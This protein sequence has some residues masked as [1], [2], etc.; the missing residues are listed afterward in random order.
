MY[1]FRLKAYLG[2]NRLY[3]LDHLRVAAYEHI[4][5]LLPLEIVRREKIMENP[6]PSLPI[7]PSKVRDCGLKPEV[8][9]FLCHP[10]QFLPEKVNIGVLEAEEQRDGN[11]GA[12]IQ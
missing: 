9:M 12:G 2:Q 4:R 3:I 6:H 1:I 7:L 5:F 10:F 11:C 8:G